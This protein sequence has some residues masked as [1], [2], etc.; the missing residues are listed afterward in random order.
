ML[1]IAH[2]IKEVQ[3]RIEDHSLSNNADEHWISRSHDTNLGNT[4]GS[5]ASTEVDAFYA[6]SSTTRSRPLNRTVAPAWAPSMA[7]KIGAI[8]EIPM[9]SC[10]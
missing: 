3:S 2:G 5:G 8:V 1:A 9:S 4:P 10:P 6:T 7:W